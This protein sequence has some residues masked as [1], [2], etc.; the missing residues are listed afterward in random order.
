MG[1]QRHFLGFKGV[2]Q[3][4]QFHLVKYGGFHMMIILAGREQYVPEKH[5]FKYF[6]NA[7]VPSNH[8][9]Y[10]LRQDLLDA[11][12][13]VYWLKLDQVEAASLGALA[14]ISTGTAI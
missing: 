13:A 4:D 8:P 11:G 9:A 7:A 2:E 14:L 12:K 5:T 3:S 6:W 10:Q 1:F